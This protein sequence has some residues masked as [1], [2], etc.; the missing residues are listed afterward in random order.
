MDRPTTSKIKKVDLITERGAVKF[1]I[2]VQV[3]TE[4]IWRVRMATV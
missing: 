2:T 1:W 4:T 3:F